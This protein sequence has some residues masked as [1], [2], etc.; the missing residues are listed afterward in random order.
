[1][2]PVC[3][4]D[5][6]VVVVGCCLFGFFVLSKLMFM[7]IDFSTLSCGFADFPRDFPPIQCMCMCIVYIRVCRWRKRMKFGGGV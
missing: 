3:F 5:V 4:F 7:F 1:M 2:F 6:V